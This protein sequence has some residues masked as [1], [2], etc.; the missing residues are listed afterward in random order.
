LLLLLNDFDKLNIKNFKINKILNKKYN[1]FRE[2]KIIMTVCPYS[3]TQN[4][5][6]NAIG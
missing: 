2:I 5:L 4:D 1:D 3:T 6:D